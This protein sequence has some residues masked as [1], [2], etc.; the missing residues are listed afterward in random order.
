MIAGNFSFNTITATQSLFGGLLNC[1]TINLTSTAFYL[2][3]MVVSFEIFLH[4]VDH[5]YRVLHL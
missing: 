3:V 2:N 5:S 1:S 4:F